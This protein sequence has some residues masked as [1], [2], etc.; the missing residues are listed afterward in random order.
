[1]KKQQNADDAAEFGR[2]R[3]VVVDEVA[4]RRRVA[5]RREVAVEDHS[6]V[7]PILRRSAPRSLMA[8]SAIKFG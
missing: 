6:R 3:G 2:G 7:R 1:M 5:A 4:D 8:F